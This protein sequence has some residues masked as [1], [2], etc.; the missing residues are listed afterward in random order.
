[1]IPSRRGPD[2]GHR[3]RNLPSGAVADSRSTLVFCYAVPLS[4]Y[5][6]RSASP[7]SGVGAGIRCRGHQIPPVRQRQRGSGQNL[8]GWASFC[9]ATF[10]AVL[11]SGP[12]L[13]SDPPL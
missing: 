6:P 2:S 7:S 10:D 11:I 9:A 8:S 5:R 1:M 3:P 13:G 12:P 4:H